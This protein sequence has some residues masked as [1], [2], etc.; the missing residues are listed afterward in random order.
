MAQLGR[1]WRTNLLPLSST[2]KCDHGHMVVVRGYGGGDV[3]ASCR[4]D[5]VK[6]IY[7]VVYAKGKLHDLVEVV[8]QGEGESRATAIRH[9]EFS[10]HL[11][12]ILDDVDECP[13][14][15]GG[16][17]DIELFRGEGGQLD[18][19]EHDTV[20]RRNIIVGRDI[21]SARSN[22]RLGR[23]GEYWAIDNKV[24]HVYTRRP[25]CTYSVVLCVVLPGY[26]EVFP[27]YTES[28]GMTVHYCKDEAR[29]GHY[30][31]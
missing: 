25:G 23:G 17:D 20:N 28:V 18:L 13:A 27:I 5:F 3:H 26:I 7:C 19:P 24:I 22:I 31:E 14:L 8:A 29:G 21:E 2:V 10:V 9:I 15:M 1:G 11:L 12:G 16:H 30:I 4:L 6:V